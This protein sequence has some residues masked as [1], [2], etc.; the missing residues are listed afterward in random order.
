MPPPTAQ[1]CKDCGVRYSQNRTGLCRTCLKAAGLFYGV[2]EVE[3]RRLEEQRARD[4]RRKVPLEEL[5]PRPALV[6]VIN[7]VEFEI[8]WDGS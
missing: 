1:A 8:N 2:L 4:Q 3:R 6:K 5:Q 7:G